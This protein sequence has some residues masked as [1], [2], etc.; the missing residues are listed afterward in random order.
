MDPQPNASAQTDT[1]VRVS[2]AIEG[3][4]EGASVRVMADGEVIAQL[5]AAP[6]VEVAWR[7]DTPGS[8]ALYLEVID[9]QQKPLARSGLVIVN[10]VSPTA[11]PLPPTATPEP[12]PL[13]VPSATPEAAAA[14]VSATVTA[15]AA[16]VEAASAVVSGTI[17]NARS[18]PGVTYAILT[19][20]NPDA[21]LPVTGKSADGQWWQVTVNGAPA[22]V[23]GALVKPN[24]SA[25]AAPVV[26]APPPPTAAPVAAATAI[27]APSAT[28]NLV[29]LGPTQTP[30]PAAATADPATAGLPPCNPDNQFWAVR[31]HKDD[32]YTFCTPVPL[33]F[34]NGNANETI[35]LRWHIYG[36]DKLE[37]RVD[38]RGLDCGLGSS[39]FKEWVPFKTET[40]VLNRSHFKRGGYKIGLW[41]TLAD[42]RVQ[43]WGELDFCGT[44]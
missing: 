8:H 5:P 34:V 22:W 32:G 11:T 30:I 41:A 27:P 40:F 7:S 26:Q 3:A 10:L 42:G 25:A 39:G 35:Q 36:I 4:P 44:G 24:A 16:P 33:D 17:I 15:A 13:P 2:G 6:A 19:Q 28:Q 18:G 1:E 14:V 20:L 43:D 31:I 38:P 37:L 21:V 29:A 12:T 23:F 9:V